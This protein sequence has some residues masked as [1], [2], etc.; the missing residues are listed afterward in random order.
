[1][2]AT[3]AEKVNAS[4]EGNLLCEAFPSGSLRCAA[5]ST[6]SLQHGIKGLGFRV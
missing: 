6:D 5:S 1:M 4:F 3:L 2:V